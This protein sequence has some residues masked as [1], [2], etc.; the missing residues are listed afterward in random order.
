MAR[1]VNF[2]AVTNTFD[3]ANPV[4]LALAEGARAVH[5]NGGL[6]AP[7]RDAD[8]R[9]PVRGQ[10]SQRWWPSPAWIA[11]EFQRNRLLQGFNDRI[12]RH[13]ADRRGCCGSATAAGR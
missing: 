11:F 8:F 3:N 13:S 2:R 5:R 10:N 1:R 12:G 7:V 4:E 9:L 6:R